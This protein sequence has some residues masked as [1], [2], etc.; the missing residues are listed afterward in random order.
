MPVLLEDEDEDEP[1]V[2]TMRGNVVLAYASTRFAEGGVERRVK[3]VCVL[4]ILADKV[5]PE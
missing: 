5:A 2:P 4:F 1:G 3:F